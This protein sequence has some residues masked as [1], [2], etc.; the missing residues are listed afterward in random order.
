MMIY[1]PPMRINLVIIIILFAIL[2][3][4]DRKPP[5]FNQGI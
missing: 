2:V 3:K 4:V 5:D 1:D